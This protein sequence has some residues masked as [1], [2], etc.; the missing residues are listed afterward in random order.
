MKKTLKYIL[1]AAGIMAAAAGCEKDG[2]KLI[3]STP[4]TPSEFSATPLEISLSAD[5]ADALALT[6]VW[7]E[8]AAAT[9]SDPTVAMPDGLVSQAVQFSASETFDDWAEIDVDSDKASLQLTGNQLS[10]ILVKLGLTDVNKYNIY[11]RLAIALGKTEV[12]SSVIKLGITPYAMETGWMKVVDKNDGTT[13]VATLHCKDATPHL[14][15]GFV[16]TTA[17][18]YNILFFAADGVQ[19]GCDSNWTAFSLVSGSTN[20]CWFAEP[21]GCQYVFADTKNQLW[22]HI[23]TPSVDATV[24]GTAVTLS[25]SKTAGGFSGAITTTA[26]NTSV[27]ISGTG[28]RYDSTTGTDAGISGISYPF[29]LIPSADGSFEFAAGESAEANLTVEKA[30]TYTLTFNVTDCT[31]TLTEGEGGGDEGGETDPWAEYPDPDYAAA[32]GEL[33]YLYSTD[34][35]KNAVTVNG[36]LL[37][38]EGKYQG[39]YYF[40]GWENFVFGDSDVAA[41][42]KVY[43]SAPVSD[44]GLYRLFC[45]SSRWAI[46]FPSGTAAYTRVSVDMTERS[47]GYE[48]VN[49]ISIVGDFNNWSLTTDQMTFDSTAKTWSADINPSSWGTY[50]MHFVVNSDWDWCLSDANSDGVLD[51]GKSDFMP[52]A[53]AGALKVTIDL[54]DPQNMTVK[55]E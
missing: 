51:T 23:Y 48:A 13:V 40:A 36:K 5:K 30:G 37:L 47:W 10:Q 50:G 14:F 22:Y 3:V 18:W 1:A 9:L 20:N 43:G 42:A 44:T 19:W 2:E 26:D 55:F 11:V 45:G 33:L 16:V 38:N 15:E 12:Y 41:S 34:S 24:D 7:N 53:A 17:G 29:S 54:N 52:T 39:Y 8:G 21:K 6:L 32:T 35:D 25:Y 46:W 4:G 31:W 49:T 27:K 28:T